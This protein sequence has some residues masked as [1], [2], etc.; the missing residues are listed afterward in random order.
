MA[1]TVRTVPAA[2]EP[3]PTGL[4]GAKKVAATK[5]ETSKRK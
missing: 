2:R 5:P 1:K 3:S 4:A